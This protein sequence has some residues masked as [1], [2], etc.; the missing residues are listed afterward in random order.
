MTAQTKRPRRRAD[1]PRAAFTPAPELIALGNEIAARYGVPLCRVRGPSKKPSLV[2]A[3]QDW[4]LALGEAGL[5]LS[6]A[7]RVTG[8]HHH[9][10]VLHGRRVAKARRAAA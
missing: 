2:A 6:Q 8:G 10:T 5:T 7:G 1:R 4:W 9:T 3:R